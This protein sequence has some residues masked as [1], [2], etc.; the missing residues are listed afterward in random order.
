MTMKQSMSLVARFGRSRNVKIFLHRENATS[1]VL[2]EGRLTSIGIDKFED[3]NRYSLT[4]RMSDG[5]NI[6]SYFAPGSW[7]YVDRIGHVFLRQA[8]GFGSSS[9][10][11]HPTGGRFY[12]AIQLRTN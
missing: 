1:D 11:V 7:T 2:N 5:H 8:K 4:W 6:T 3:G 12:Y 10:N 9:A